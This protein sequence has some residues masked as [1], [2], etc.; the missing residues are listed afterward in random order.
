MSRKR[1]KLSKGVNDYIPT[2]VNFSQLENEFDEN[3]T[4]FDVSDNL[5]E[6]KKMENEF[7]YDELV[8]QILYNLDET[9]KIVFLYQL[10][11]DGGFQIDHKSFA[12]TM[13]LQIFKYDDVLKTIQVKIALIVLGYKTANT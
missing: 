4:E 6:V 3:E 11:R 9:E 7:A 8:V 2:S 13:G 12:K 10:L 1:I 5:E